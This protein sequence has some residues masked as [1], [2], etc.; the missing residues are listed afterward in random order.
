LRPSASILWLKVNADSRHTGTGLPAPSAKALA[1]Y[2]DGNLFAAE[3]NV[4]L[5]VA[6]HAQPVDDN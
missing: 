6:Q 3:L 4:R 5:P 1:Y 2:E